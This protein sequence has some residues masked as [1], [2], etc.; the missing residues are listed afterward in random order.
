MNDTT[1][2]KKLR[3]KTGVKKGFALHDWK[4][5]L[6]RSND[7]AQRK[8]APLRS[9]TMEEVAQ[10]DKEYDGWM[11]LHGKVYNIGPY[12]HYHP[13]GVNIL[14]PSLGKDGS[15]LFEQYHRWVGIENLIGKL[16]IGYIDDSPQSQMSMP[17]P[18]PG[19]QKLD[20]L[21]EPPMDRD[22][23]GQEKEDEEETVNPWEK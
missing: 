4:L 8:G 9:M 15:N 13:G 18:K 19:L 14:G 16:L 17:P 3:R 2:P 12:I 21:L 6:N 20:N 11:V 1:L 22:Q 5:L 23:N 10:H 7:L